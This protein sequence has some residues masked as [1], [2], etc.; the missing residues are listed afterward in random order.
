MYNGKGLFEPLFFSRISTYIRIMF[1]DSTIEYLTHD[2]FLLSLV[3]FLFFFPEFVMLYELPLIYYWIPL[4]TVGTRLFIP[5]VIPDSITSTLFHY[6]F[7]LFNIAI[8]Y[9][10]LFFLAIQSI[11]VWICPLVIL[12][13]ILTVQFT[14]LLPDY[15]NRIIER[16]DRRRKLW[17]EC[18]YIERT[19]NGDK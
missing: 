11:W 6:L 10:T 14:G 16:M 19:K 9:G 12:S 2:D 18:E 3:M 8:G 7:L 5:A 4:V 15:R 1:S 13:I 17:T